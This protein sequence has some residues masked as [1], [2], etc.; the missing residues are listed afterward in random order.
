MTG[1]ENRAGGE[2]GDADAVDG[3]AGRH[4]HRR[5]AGPSGRAGGFA[6]NVSAAVVRRQLK[7]RCS[8][9]P[10]TNLNICSVRSVLKLF[11]LCEVAPATR[12]ERVQIFWRRARAGITKLITT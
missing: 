1:A 9:Q 8:V 2:I 10:A 11:A 3:I 7:R 5:H 6:G 12:M 4:P